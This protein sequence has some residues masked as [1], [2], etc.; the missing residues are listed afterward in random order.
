VVHSPYVDRILH[1]SILLYIPTL[2]K[3]NY[4]DGQYTLEIS[5]NSTVLNELD[6]ADIIT[7]PALNTWIT[8]DTTN[9]IELFITV[10][11]DKSQTRDNGPVFITT[12]C[13]LRSTKSS[14]ILD[15]FIKDALKFYIRTTEKKF[16]KDDVFHLYI[17]NRIPI[18]DRKSGNDGLPIFKRYKLSNE[19]TFETLF[20]P[21]KTELLNILDN[22]VHQ[23]DKFAIKGFP[24]KIGLLLYGPPGTGK[25][26]L[27]KALA[28]YTKRNVVAVSLS[29]I[30]TNEQLMDIIY[31]KPIELAD[32][33]GIF[34]LLHKEV[35][36]V[37][38]DID[39]AS[40]IVSSRSS[41][42]SNESTTIRETKIKSLM[43]IGPRKEE[44]Q[45][46]V[47]A[48][49][50]ELNDQLNLAGLL[51]VLDGIIDSPG[52]IIVMTTNHPEHL[53]P[54]LIRPGRIDK[55]IYMGYIQT[56][57]VQ[58]MLKYYFPSWTPSLDDEKLINKCFHT[59]NNQF[60]PAQVEHQCIE[61]SSAPDV[62]AH[63]ANLI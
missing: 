20:F 10:E 52:R 40:D 8:I 36:Y 2:E 58:Q 32:E 62:V 57:E 23:T 31:G 3:S 15:T 53:D 47:E 46:Q 45:N 54:A 63:F 33:P 14:E 13:K 42:S 24:Y 43:P 4:S 30:R 35:I 12:T 37:F 19:K 6:K 29:K 26:S 16:K 17:L 18:K 11:I 39:C 56:N 49:L 59:N 55:M 41:S 51:N 28:Q 34:R 61:C 9:Q 27:I 44:N 25:T 50:D 48:V 21:W 38:E 5:T 22:F 60:T 7:M 1:H